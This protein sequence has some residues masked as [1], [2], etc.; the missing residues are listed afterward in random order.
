MYLAYLGSVRFFRV[1]RNIGPAYESR[2][3]KPVHIRDIT[4]L[5]SIAYSSATHLSHP[6]HILAIPPPSTRTSWKS[7][8]GSPTTTTTTT[9]KHKFLYVRKTLWGTVVGE[10]QKYHT[11]DL[12]YTASIDSLR[13]NP[14]KLTTT[15]KPPKRFPHTLPTS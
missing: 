8:S 3:N 14:R 4:L 2:P 7:P 5:K 1:I 12:P 11:S 9:V 15:H 13:C 6:H 10:K